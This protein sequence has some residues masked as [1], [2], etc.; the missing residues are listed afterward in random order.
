MTN[1]TS[2]SDPVRLATGIEARLIEAEAQLQSNPAAW[3]ATLNALRADWANLAGIVR[4]DAAATL[5][6]L[7]DPGTAAGREDLHF[8]ERA[9]WLHSTGSRLSDLRRMIRQY[10]RSEG[11]IFPT[12]GYFK[13]GATFGT[14]V[15]WPVPDDEDNNPNNTG[16]TDLSA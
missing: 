15:N 9:F 4:G 6:A 12:G 2:R 10:G 16:C 5:A 13:A 3:L 1:D 11:S 8:R 7:V 14:L